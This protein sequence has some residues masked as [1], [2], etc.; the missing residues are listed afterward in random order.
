MYLT[1]SDCRN[2]NL[3]TALVHS[4]FQDNLEISDEEKLIHL[5]SKLSK[6]GSETESY[7]HS[8]VINSAYKKVCRVKQKGVV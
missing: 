3:P 4:V 2:S 8:L 7:E 6:A 5:A 1:P